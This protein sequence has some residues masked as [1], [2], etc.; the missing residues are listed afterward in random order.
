MMHETDGH[1]F[2]P[3]GRLERGRLEPPPRVAAELREGRD[4]EAADA[5]KVSRRT[6]TDRWGRDDFRELVQQ[7]RDRFGHRTARN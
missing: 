4:E 6:V 1:R 7:A 3:V 5:V 2:D